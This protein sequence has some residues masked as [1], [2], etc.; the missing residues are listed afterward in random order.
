MQSLTLDLQTYTE[1]T[2]GQGCKQGGM[3]SSSVGLE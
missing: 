3:G 1:L 2:A